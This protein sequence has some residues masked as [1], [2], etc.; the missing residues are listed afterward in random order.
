M[1]LQFDKKV[2]EIIPSHPVKTLQ[3]FITNRCNK[4]CPE[5]FYG[6][7]LDKEDMPFDDYKSYI[8]KFCDPVNVPKVIIIG[9]EPTLHPRLQDM[10]KFNYD[11]GLRTTIYTNGT[12]PGALE[13]LV[14]LNLTVRVGVH[15]L[16]FGPKPIIKLQ[17]PD[18]KITIV[19]M[20][21]TFNF[22]DL[23][24][25]I[26]Y[27]EQNF[28]CEDFYISS[29]RELQTSR[30]FWLDTENTIP[31]SPALK[32]SYPNIINSFLSG[33]NGNI[34]RLHICKR[35]VFEDGDQVQRCRYL[36]IFPDG[37]MVVCPW[38]IPLGINRFKDT[39]PHF[40]ICKKNNGKC[41]L[42]KVILERR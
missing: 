31:L 42:Q 23:D 17:P 10:V 21:D 13:N 30:N 27:T 19:F 32:F 34:K 2:W 5:C 8:K 12:Q 14:D 28:N 7:Y 36:N 22:K 41:I 9:G 26:N 11:N 3:L 29:I 1:N 38:D 15:S 4:K 39:E 33:Y 16:I 37:N 24:Q 40:E 20:L 18:Y 25:I 35:G 6:A